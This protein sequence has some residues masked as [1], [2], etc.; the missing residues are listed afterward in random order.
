MMAL[1]RFLY[2]LQNLPF[3]IQPKYFADINSEVNKLLWDGHNARIARNKLTRSWYD[4]GIALPS[5]QNYYWAAHLVVLNQWVHA[6]QD[7]PAYRMDW[8]LL[9]T[10]GILRA[11]YRTPRQQGLTGPTAH[12]VKIWYEAQRS[13]GRHGVITQATPLWDT[14]KLGTLRNTKGFRQWD[15]VGISTVGDMWKKGKILTFK[16]LQQEYELAEMEIYRYLQIHHALTTLIPPGSTLPEASPLEDR[17][18]TDH[19]HTKAIS[20]TYKKIINSSPDP[21]KALKTKWEV[22]LGQLD[23]SE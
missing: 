15:L 13:L 1:P 17:L 11:L 22:D 5:I 19:M 14:K 2:A 16:E 10:D 18:L 4:G 12:T 8:H 6:P 21:T 7:E 9:G 3:P 20:L 23:E